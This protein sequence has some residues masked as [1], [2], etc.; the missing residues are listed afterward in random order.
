ML[1]VLKS[2]SWKQQVSSDHSSSR[3]YHE[4]A[5]WPGSQNH[6]EGLRGGWQRF[7]E[8]ILCAALPQISCCLC[9]RDCSDCNILPKPFRRGLMAEIALSVQ[10]FVCLC[11]T[12][13]VQRLP[14]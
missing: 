10:W 7:Q 8:C 12:S 11:W 13:L 14:R 6:S 3:A 1:L 5:C 4:C 9:L 2:L